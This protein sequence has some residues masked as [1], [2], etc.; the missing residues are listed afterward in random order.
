MQLQ[1]TLF[2]EKLNHLT[3]ILDDASEGYLTASINARSPEMELYFEK[4]SYQRKDFAREIKKIVNSMGATSYAKGGFLSL[5]HRT[6][7]DMSYQLKSRDKDAV[8]TC[9]IIGEKFASNYY[10]SILNDEDMPTPVKNV[11]ML[12]HNS[13]QASL[14]QFEKVSRQE[15]VLEPMAEKEELVGNQDLLLN[16]LAEKK[17]MFLISYL[18]HIS[19]DFETIAD[20]MEDRNLRNTFFSLAEENSQ[21]A[22]Q[23]NCQAKQY[24]FSFTGKDLSQY[25]LQAEEDNY[26]ELVTATKKNELMQICDKSEYLFLKLYTDALKEFLSFKNLKE[27]MIYQYNSIRAGFFKLRLLN[28]LRHNNEFS[29]I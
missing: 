3:A 7:K 9:C 5:L 22:E 18:Q 25:W 28:S 2:V 14:K 11:L 8:K 27:M 13:I 23:L 15:A 16:E 26:N 19:K 20:E 10:E 17:M 29:Q 24:G 4:L 21:F 6:W 1:Q 12:Q